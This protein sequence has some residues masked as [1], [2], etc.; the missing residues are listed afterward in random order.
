MEV[1][2]PM[3]FSMLIETFWLL[4][5]LSFVSLLLH[6]DIHLANSSYRG[7]SATF[8]QPF[9]SALALGSVVFLIVVVVWRSIEHLVEVEHPEIPSLFYDDTFG[10]IDASESN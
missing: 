6:L 4:F 10:I 2:V 7:K 8:F 5:C 1:N 9:P 3:M